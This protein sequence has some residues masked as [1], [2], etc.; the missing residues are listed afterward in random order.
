MTY[1]AMLDTEWLFANLQENGKPIKP[2]SRWDELLMRQ[3]REREQVL[4]SDE[5]SVKRTTSTE[6]LR[7][8]PSQIAVR[9]ME[10]GSSEQSTSGN[11]SESDVESESEDDKEE[12]QATHE[13]IRLGVRDQR[14]DSVESS[15]SAR[16]RADLAREIFSTRV[17]ED[18]AQAAYGGTGDLDSD[19]EDLSLSASD[20]A[21]LNRA[22]LS[23]IV[24]GSA[25]PSDIEE[26]FHETIMR[27][28]YGSTLR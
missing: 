7:P 23:G 25:L 24:F 17:R 11:E 21:E 5:R 26:D 9:A 13:Q 10:E 18:L 16:M 6:T 22:G 14:S 8:T 15:F 3:Q 1:L 2:R 20:R 4:L 12:I 28:T 27:Q 19:N